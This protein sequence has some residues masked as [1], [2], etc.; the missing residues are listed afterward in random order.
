MP[1]NEFIPTWRQALAMGVAFGIGG[2][3][4]KALNCPADG[5]TCC[6]KKAAAKADHK[7]V[8][9]LLVHL[10]FKEGGLSQFL[11]KWTAVA[12]HCREH[13]P[14]T[15]TYELSRSES[16]KNSVIIYERYI[17]KEDLAVTHN[18]SRPFT[19]LQEFLVETNIVE[20]K[21]IEFFYESNIGYTSK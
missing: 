16:D 12:N 10:K 20:S 4:L 14:N 9:V 5:W 6:K 18:T 2:C 21:S 19:K 7:N 8:L 15:L 17:Q 3:I 1:L 13:E 11:E